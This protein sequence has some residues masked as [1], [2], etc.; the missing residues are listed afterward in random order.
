MKNWGQYHAKLMPFS[1]MFWRFLI[2]VGSR[3]PV[4]AVLVCRCVGSSG[5]P[6]TEGEL[7]VYHKG[8]KL[9]YILCLRLLVSWSGAVHSDYVLVQN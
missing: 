5:R 7:E 1:V 9:N 6:H 4:A 8:N 3:L 2:K